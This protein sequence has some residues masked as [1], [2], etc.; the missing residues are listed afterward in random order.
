MRIRGHKDG[1]THVPGWAERWKDAFPAVAASLN[2]FGGVSVENRELLSILSTAQTQTDW[3]DSGPVCTDLAKATYDFGSLKENPATV[4][5]ILPPNRLATHSTWLRIM[6][7]AI[8]TPL[9]RSVQR[10]KVPV[11]LMLDEFAQLG[12][13][14]VI[15]NNLGMMREYGVKLG[16][17]S[18]TSLKHK[19]SI[20]HGGRAL[21]ET[22]VCSIPLRPK[23]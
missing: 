19:N 20:V 15:E 3:L 2:R 9:L 17:F 1:D 14:P 6:I 23:T 7:T 11:L 12:H 21:S 10:A 13:M 16:R 4:Y 22:L 8:L 5:L 18:K